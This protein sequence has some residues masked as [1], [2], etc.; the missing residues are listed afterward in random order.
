MM[1]KENVTPAILDGM[2]GQATLPALPAVPGRQAL[3]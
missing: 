3:H 2:L 1:L